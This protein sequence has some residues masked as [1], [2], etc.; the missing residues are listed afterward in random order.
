[1]PKRLDIQT[2]VIL[3]LIAILGPTFLMLTTF[4]NRFLS[5]ILEDEVRVTALAFVENLANQIESRRLLDSSNPS[6]MIEDRIQRMVYAQPSILRVDVLTETSKRELESLASNVEDDEPGRW[7]GSQLVPNLKISSDTEDDVPVLRILFPF[8]VHGKLYNIDALVSLRLV[9]SLKTTLSRFNLLAALMTG[10]ALVFGL[11]FSLR[12]VFDNEKRLILAQV[13]N[14]ELAGRLQILQQ[15]LLQKEK[16]AVMGQLTASFAHEIGTPLNSI[17]GHLQLLERD[18]QKMDR[19]PVIQSILERTNVIRGQIQRIEGIVKG[20]LE[21]TRR[22]G[23]ER[24]HTSVTE[25]LERTAALVAP[26]F[27]RHEVELKKVWSTEIPQV[28]VAAVE[29]EQI[30]LNFINNAI[31]AISENKSEKM[32]HGHGVIEIDAYEVSWNS[33]RTLEIVVRDNGAGISAE[34][35]KRIFRPFFTTKSSENGHGL[36][37]SICQDIAKGYGGEIAIE[38][39]PGSGTS[40]F[41]RLPLEKQEPAA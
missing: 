2:K 32:N 29:V 33:K 3:V 30:L 16:L 7:A 36:G 18:V 24:K 25:I 39:K 15:E 27:Q 23:P 19:N 21:S 40:A 8:K 11:F 35:M 10:L 6:K 22:K 4:Q 5:P 13:S 12:R 9:S 14:E 28:N 1:M 37:L 17:G 26:T 20:F 41:L 34:N 31:D 38:S